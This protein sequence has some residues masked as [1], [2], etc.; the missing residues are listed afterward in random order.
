MEEK[1]REKREMGRE[2]REKEGKEEA[3]LIDA[4]IHRNPVTI[5]HCTPS[6]F[7]PLIIALWLSLCLGWEDQEEKG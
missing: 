2:E 5:R 1:S 3:V 7:L 4:G 6:P